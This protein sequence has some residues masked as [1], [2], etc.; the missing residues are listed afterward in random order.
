MNL[1]LIL[2]ALITALTGA[3]SGVRAPA[4]QVEQVAAQRAA[5]VRTAVAPVR[6]WLALVRGYPAAEVARPVAPLLHEVPLYLAKR[7]E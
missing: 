4:V 1:L 5:A 3:F 7:R 2:S 6:P